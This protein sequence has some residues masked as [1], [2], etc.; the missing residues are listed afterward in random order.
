MST[1]TYSNNRVE[2]AHRFLKTFIPHSQGDLFSTWLVIELAIANQMRKI[3]YETSRLRASTPLDI[4]RRMFQACFSTVTVSALREVN[5]YNDA[6]ARPL[7]PCTGAHT[8]TTGLPCAHKIDQRREAGLGL[9][10]EDFHPHWYWDR[11]TTALEPPIL[12]PLQVISRGVPSRRDKTAKKSTTRIPSGFEATETRKRICSLCKLPGHNRR[13][14][15]CI[16]NLRRD[17]QL[18]KLQTYQYYTAYQDQ[19]LQDQQLQDQQLQDQQLQDQQ[20]LGSSP[21]P[22]PSALCS[23]TST[24]GT[25]V[26]EIP[27]AQEAAAVGN[28][29]LH[30]EPQSEVEVE[31]LVDTRPIWPGRIEVIY[32]QYLAAKE[33]WLA[34]NPDIPASGYRQSR[35][36][37]IWSVAKRKYQ[38]RALKY[39]NRIDLSTGRELEGSPHWTT[40]EIDAYI[41]YQEEKEVVLERQLEAEFAVSGYVSKERGIGHIHRHI[42]RE[43]AADRAQYRYAP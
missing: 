6:I 15:Q 13:S 41:D 26:V 40:E 19:Q 8:R 35:G 5:R 29:G 10:P 39:M 20:L 21:D 3:T 1:H 18:K 34:A 23:E 22:F 24:G 30:I 9:Q 25:I 2:G 27:E 12:E 43:L 37:L 11:H 33:E 31:A 4:D 7:P 14:G 16:V 28:Q 17:Q 32:A 36:F 42:E 38:T